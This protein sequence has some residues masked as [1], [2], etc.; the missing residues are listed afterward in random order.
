MVGI[1]EREGGIGRCR[2]EDGEEERKNGIEKRDGSIDR[3][4]E[5]E[6]VLGTEGGTAG[7][8]NKVTSRG[9]C[10]KLT[11]LGACR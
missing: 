3:E 6:T 1:G 2:E 10:Y 11:R 4:T 7:S 8:E 9:F 5:G